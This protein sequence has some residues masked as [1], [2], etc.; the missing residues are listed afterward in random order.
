MA[1]VSRIQERHQEHDCCRRTGATLSQSIF[2]GSE[3]LLECDIRDNYC[4]EAISTESY[5]PVTAAG[6]KSTLKSLRTRVGL[7]QDRL[8]TTELALDALER[9]ESVRA[10]QARGLNR[11]VAIVEA[12]RE[13]ARSLPI[14]DNLIVDAALSLRINSGITNNSTLYA[15]DLSDRRHALLEAWDELHTARGEEPP[16]KPT[17][18]SLRLDREDSAFS[19][20]ASVLVGGPPVSRQPEIISASIGST[21]HGDEGAK[22]VV[23]GA[24]VYDISCRTRDMPTPNTSAQAYDFEERPGGKGLNQAVGLARLGVP[25]RLISP[26]GSDAAAS[27]ILDYLRIEGVDSRYV[28]ICHGAKSP[29]TVVLSFKSGSFLHIGWKNEHEVRLSGEFVQSPAIRKTIES[30]SVILLTLEPTRETIGTIFRVLARS[31]RCPLILTASPPIEVPPLSG[32]DLHAIDYLVASDWELH[33][34]LEDTGDDDGA[35]SSHDII[36]RLLLAGVGRICVL[37]SNE[38][39]I[40]GVPNDFTQPTPA[41]VVVTDQSAAKDAFAAALAARIAEKGSATEE[42]FHYAYYAMLAS[43][44]RFG[45]SSSLPTNDEISSLQELINQR[46]SILIRGDR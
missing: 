40:Y 25:V 18:R 41:A 9:L 32:S 20:L 45:T 38:C 36:D 4:E 29:R 17:V 21:V 14:T 44:M 15:A 19:L 34:M 13:G 23:I 24:A 42:D 16:P 35:L 28:E 31:K 6:V 46:N 27:E 10:L 30:A 22:A 26:I 12:V 2:F 3:A 7:Q 33:Y 11:V 43:E 39:R 5:H 1:D 37:G 8:S